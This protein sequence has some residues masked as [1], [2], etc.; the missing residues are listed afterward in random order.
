MNKALKCFAVG[1]VI[2]I[3]LSLCFSVQAKTSVSFLYDKLNEATRL[4]GLFYGNTVHRINIDY[5]DVF[6]NERGDFYARV[7]E[8][9]KSLAEYKEELLKH[10]DKTLV[11]T[12]AARNEVEMV[13]DTTLFIEKDG[14]LYFLSGWV[15]A[16]FEQE[17]TEENSKIEI[18]R[19][20]ADEIEFKMTLLLFKKTSYTYTLKKENGNF[21]FKNFCFPFGSDMPQNLTINPQTADAPLVCALVFAALSVFAVFL[22][23]R[24]IKE[25]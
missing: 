22:V 2:V 7:N 5:D 3:T 8:N 6:Q 14:K 17:L 12:I 16:K 9:F 20:S 10:F 15:I 13:E 25:R 11:T 24:K 1:I 18:L 21:V 4:A 23:T 19:E